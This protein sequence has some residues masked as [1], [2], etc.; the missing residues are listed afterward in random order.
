V[1]QK[2]RLL[3]NSEIWALILKM[4]FFVNS[5]IDVYPTNMWMPYMMNLVRRLYRTGIGW[6]SIVVV[7]CINIQAWTRYNNKCGAYHENCWIN[8]KNKGRRHQMGCTSTKRKWQKK[9]QSKSKSVEDGEG[10]EC[11]CSYKMRSFVIHSV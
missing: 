11:S 7:Y 10:G 8:I 1:K 2:H 5:K 3:M 4:N 9:S 6:S